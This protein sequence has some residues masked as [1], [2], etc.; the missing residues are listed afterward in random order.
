MTVIQPRYNLFYDHLF[1]TSLSAKLIRCSSREASLS[2]SNW[3]KKLFRGTNLSAVSHQIKLTSR[4]SAIDEA[5]KENYSNLGFSPIL[6]L[7]LCHAVESPQG[8][9]SSNH[10]S[11]YTS[12]I[13]GLLRLLQSHL[14]TSEFLTLSIHLFRGLPSLLTS[15]LSQTLSSPPYFSYVH[16]RSSCSHL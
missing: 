1:L 2:R 7:C 14:C 11:P 12:A 3:R 8:L 13:H 5:T 15:V 9:G 16:I 10:N 6:S 4:T